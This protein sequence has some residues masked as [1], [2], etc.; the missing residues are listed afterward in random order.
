MI[1]LLTG[2]VQVSLGFRCQSH[3]VGWLTRVPTAVLFVG[4]VDHQTAVGVDGRPRQQSGH[5]VYIES[6]VEPAVSDVV[7]VTLRLTVELDALTFDGRR[8]LRRKHDI[9]IT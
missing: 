3:S 8:V 9:G 4:S 2:N 5:L 7:W 6:V 1:I